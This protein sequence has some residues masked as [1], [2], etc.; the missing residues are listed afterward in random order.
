MKKAY[1]VLIMLLF[2]FNVNSIVNADINYDTCPIAI[3]L[4]KVASETTKFLPKKINGN[5]TMVS[6]IAFGNRIIYTNILDFTKKDFHQYAK[7]VGSTTK[8]LIEK[9]EKMIVKMSCSSKIKQNTLRRG[10]I[11]EYQTLFSDGEIYTDLIVD[12]NTSCL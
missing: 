10:A 1:V 6:C 11:Y 5:S 7:Q 12:K 2:Y 3:L 4:E 8:A 9:E